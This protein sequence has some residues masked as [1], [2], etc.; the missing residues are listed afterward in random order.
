[1]SKW[2]GYLGKSLLGTMSLYPCSF[3]NSILC[4]WT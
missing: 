4:V 1:M 3:N 2:G